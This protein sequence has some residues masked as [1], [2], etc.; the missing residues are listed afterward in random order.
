MPI[1]VFDLKRQ[2]QAIKSEIDYAV[3]KVLTKGHFTLGNEVATFER[4]F[5]EY[6]GSSF[7]IGVASGTDALTLALRA[8][9]IGP[10][11]EVIVPANAYPTAFGLAMSGV[12]LRLVDCDETANL[13]IDKL[14]STMTAKTKAVVAVHLYGNPADIV[15][16]VDLTGRQ[17]QRIFVIED[18]AQAHGAMV[19]HNTWK[20]VGSLGDIGVFSF[21]P[22]KNLAAYGDGGLMVTDHKKIADR[23]RTLRMYGE[24][25]RYKSEEI[26]GVSR[27]DEL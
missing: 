17:K 24:G 2:Y 14:N 8:F 22:T 4:E 6:I 3:N 12:K 11:D 26:S 16:I 5:S 13:D 23:L 20:K 1:P 9:D 25:T 27:L 19:K 21:Y 7:G 18:A 15:G 10:G